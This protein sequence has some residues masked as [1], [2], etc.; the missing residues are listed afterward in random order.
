AFT[1]R[2]AGEP[3]QLDLADAARPSELSQNVYGIAVIQAFGSLVRRK[4]G[5]QAYSG[6]TSY[7][8][9]AAAF[10]SAVADG[11]V[12]AILLRIDSFGGEA[13]GCFELCDQ[14]YQARKVKPVWAVADINAMS[15]AY[16]IGCS[17]ERFYVAPSG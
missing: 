13:G 11:N 17:A 14:I 10:D 6:L 16:A 7:A 8:D 1:R 5:L 9:L 12:K 2:L 3:D 15:A 4:T